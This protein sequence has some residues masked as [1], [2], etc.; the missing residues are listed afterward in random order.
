MRYAVLLSTKP[1]LLHPRR[2]LVAPWTKRE[3][4]CPAARADRG[5]A[6]RRGRRAPGAGA[7]SRP[8]ST[9]G[10]VDPAR[11]RQHPPPPPP[12]AD[13]QRAPRAG[14]AALRLADELY[15]VWR[16]LTRR[17]WRRHARRPRR[18][19]A[20]R[21]RPPPI[22]STSSRAG[23]AADRRRDRRRPRP[24]HPLPAH[25]RL[26]EPRPSQG[27]LPPDDVVQDEDAILADCAR[28]IAR[29][30]RPAAG[31]DDAHRPRALLALLRH[32]G[33]DAATAEL[34][35]ENGV[36]L[37]THLAE[38]VDEEAFCLKRSAAGRW[39]SWEPG[40]ARAGRLVRALRPFH[41][42]GNGAVRRDAD[43]RRALPLLQHAARLR[44]RA[45]AR[46]AQGGRAGRPRRGR[47]ASNDSSKCSPR[48]ARRCSFIAAAR[49]GALAPA[50]DVLWMATR[51]GA[52]VLGRDEIGRL[53]PGK[54]ADL[55]LV[56]TAGCPTRGGQRPAGRA[57][58]LALP[59]SRWTR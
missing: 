37:H 10:K 12:D 59:A 31:R 27:G 15:E 13:P 9:P 38:T 49:P 4:A 17:R 1:L 3:R 51:G 54:A 53:A 33:T 29:V 41:R 7:E 22:T 18:T 6:D 55:I 47:S 50:Q 56:D 20:H 25:A 5:R 2:R 36:Q 57:R 34:A 39:S 58:V 24:G 14:G 8:P 43:R 21:A 32:R 40:L 44:H 48:R 30:P 46:D 28:L 19:A 11:A 52:G 26:D 23:D 35:R 45:G 42:R 16:G